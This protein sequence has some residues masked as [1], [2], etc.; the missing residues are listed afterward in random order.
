M[1]RTYIILPIVVLIGLVLEIALFSCMGLGLFLSCVSGLVL[2]GAA[3]GLGF[4]EVS[5]SN[6]IL[7]ELK[8]KH[9]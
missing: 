2:T 5:R 4:Y 7:E 9:D 6:E 8:K 3:V 1:I